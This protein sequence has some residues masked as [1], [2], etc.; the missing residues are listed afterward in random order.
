[1]KEL[2]F[3]KQLTEG[4]VQCSGA[5]LLPHLEPAALLHRVLNTVPRK[6]YEQLLSQRLRFW[7][8][9]LVHLA[10][11]RRHASTVDGFLVLVIRSDSPALQHQP[12]AA[13]E[14]STFSESTRAS[15]RPF[16][17]GPLWAI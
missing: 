17:H 7:H 4:R 16:G 1:M 6:T 2:S 8:C 9:I 12:P 11:G 10:Y 14:G 5:V 15:P 13:G 3:K